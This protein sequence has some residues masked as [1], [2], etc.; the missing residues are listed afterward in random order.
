L[1]VLQVALSVV[2]VAM[3]GLFAHSLAG[4][5][6]I[7]PGFVAQNVVT[8][9]L[10]Y[11][12][13]WKSA[14][15]QKHRERLLASLSEVPGIASISYGL[16]GPY[17][18]G[19]WSAGI[20]VPGSERTAKEANEVAEQAVGPAYFATIGMRPLR[21]R[22]FDRNDLRST[23]KIAVVNEAFVREYLPGVHDPVGRILSF[24]DS[25]PE[26][27]EPTY[28]VG[29]V[30]DIL[31]DG[32]K[33][34]AKS[35]VYIPFREADVRAS[36]DPTLLVSSHFPAASLLPIIRRQV[37]RLDPQV[38]LTEPRTL[39][40]RVDDSIFVDRMIATLSGF[41]GALALLLAA[42]GIYGVMAYAVTRR[43]AEIG[44][45][46]ALGAAPARIE[47]M[48]LRD[49]L[50]LIA[51]G[52]AIGLPLSFGMARLSETLLYGIKPNDPLAFVVT[53]AV[54][55]GTGILA[56]FLPARRAASVEPVEAL[57]HE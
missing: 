37:D 22:E 16:P 51:A 18:G 56:A 50:L 8:F 7:N 41:F 23:R 5:R 52:V 35:T 9:S 27:G 34:P 33:A 28:I 36:W 14:D 4:L 44:L 3:A 49:G 2:L 30:H 43:T 24:D 48:M 6:S 12:R 31:H 53:V 25:K 21:G 26:G 38:A 42:I 13:A 1:V 55:L 15:K 29:V 20:R 45:R 11:P 57:R 19:S 46:I 39:R 32:L 40:E 47:W 54:L 17:R 10:D